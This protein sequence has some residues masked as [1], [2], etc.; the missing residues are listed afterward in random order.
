[1]FDASLIPINSHAVTVLHVICLYEIF[2]VIKINQNRSDSIP[3]EIVRRRQCITLLFRYGFLRCS[4][5]S[6][7]ML[8]VLNAWPLCNTA[9]AG[10]RPPRHLCGERAETD[11]SAPAFRTT[12]GW[13][14]PPARDP[15]RRRP[16]SACPNRAGSRPDRRRR[17]A[18]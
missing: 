2:F 14:Y 4:R 13:N 11:R 12:R 3:F 15:G 7:A 17:P 6:N 8:F 1:M 10:F 5:L 18:G 16:F 9:V